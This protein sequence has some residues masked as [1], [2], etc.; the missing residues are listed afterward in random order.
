MNPAPRKKTRVVP[1]LLVLV[2]AA[3]FAWAGWR[4][5]GWFDEAPLAEADGWTARRGRLDVTV[6]QRGNL[7]ARNAVKVFSEVEGRNA[8][9]ELVEEGSFVEEGQVLVQLDVAQ[10]LERK[11]AQDI[12]VQNSQA[13]RTTA[14]QR[15]A[16]QESQNASDIALAEQKLDFA[17]T[18]LKKYENG[19][20]PNKLA[21]ADEAIKQAE[22]EEAQARERL[23]WS[24]DLEKDGFITKTELEA[25]Q[26]AFQRAE[27]R[28]TQ[29][30][31]SKNLLLEYD[32][33][34]ELARLEAAVREAERELERVNLQAAARLVDIQADVRTSTAKLALETEKFQKYLTQI[35]KATIR[36]PVAG[37]VVYKK[38]ESWR[39]QGD[40]IQ[41]GSEVQERQEILSIPQAGG[42]IAEVSLHESVV[43]KVQQG[44]PV[45]IKV[46]ALQPSEFNGEVQFVALVPDSGS[47]WTNPNLRQFKTQ[48]AIRDATAE[49]KPGMS[50]AVEILV[51]SVEQALTVPVQAIHRSGGKSICFVGGAQRVVELGASS[52]AWVQILAGLEAGETVALHP[53]AG[54]KPEPEP[55]SER[56]PV[57]DLPFVPPVGG[58]YGG[59]TQPSGAAGSGRPPRGEG[60]PRPP[61]T[62]GSGG[63]K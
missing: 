38:T 8:I 49:A 16:I 53:P 61:A 57:A 35:E 20:H 7:S 36:A 33:P 60:G 46:D 31:R 15:L 58:D 41:K 11:V 12:A 45:K 4:D 3:G 63:G 52:E 1:V 28:K 56:S 44:M 18:D 43:R 48:I 42:M 39:G 54:F 51:E 27:I 30:V 59:R 21:A 40:I 55:E 47:M 14:E 22:M 5:G 10:L 29:A 62:E 19:D 34:K 6:V 9:L 24:V 32:H 26:L 13:A 50:C 17:G 25:D 2:A 37:Y 23:K